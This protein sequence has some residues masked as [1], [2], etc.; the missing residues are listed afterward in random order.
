VNVT[1]AQTDTARASGRP[2]SGLERWR[3]RLSGFDA[4]LIAIVILAAVLRFWSIDFG[5]P[6]VTHPDEPLI[7][8]A[9][10]RMRDA[11]DLNPHWF[12]Y[13]AMIIYLELAVVL[14]VDALARFTDLSRE[15][16]VSAYYVGGRVVMASFG[17]ATVALVGLL[18]RRIV[19]SRGALVGLSAAGLLALSF[20]HIKDSHYLKPDVPAAFFTT[21]AL[22]FSLDAIESRRLRSW[23]LA[24]VAVGLAGAAKYNAALVALAPGVALT[25]I[26]HSPR[27]WLTQRAGLLRVV[28]VAGLMSVVALTSFLA[29]NPYIVITTGEFLSPVDG[30]TAEWEHYRQGHEGAEGNDTWI[31]YA[32][33]LWRSGFGPTIMPLVAVGIAVA[34]ARIWRGD[35]RLLLLLVF[36]AVYYLLIAQYPVRFDRQLIPI[37]PSLALLGALW[38]PWLRDRVP[39]PPRVALLA[40]PALAVV[41]AGVPLVRAA[42]WNI[43]LG[44][45]DTR[46]PALEWTQANLRHDAVIVHEHYTPPLG[47]AGFEAHLVWTVYEQPPEWFEAIGAEYVMISS[48]IYWRYLDAPDR[49]PDQAAFYERLLAAPA[50]ASFQPGDTNSGPD[51]FIYHVSDVAPI[52]RRDGV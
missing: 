45:P 48:Y 50:V 25:V 21:L 23:L 35:R 15:A 11:G 20:L 30:I 29:L 34:V 32:L 12:R 36:P 26:A 6:M 4:G 2:A 10:E 17:V 19:P 47:D 44:R 7:V 52:L 22:W 46:Y 8:A 37:L 40:L 1:G 16:V 5:V 43:E 41:V 18:G 14:A 27:A 38:L 24:A 9:A 51:I 49:Y 31:W 42:T 39:G 33:E 3:D 13:P 28:G